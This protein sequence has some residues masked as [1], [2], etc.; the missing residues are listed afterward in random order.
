MVPF[1]SPGGPQ[2]GAVSTPSPGLCLVGLEST[3]QF[4][5]P[6]PLFDSAHRNTVEDVLAFL[7]QTHS[8]SSQTPGYPNSMTVRA[9][10]ASGA[11]GRLNSGPSRKKVCTHICSHIHTNTHMQT[12][13]YVHRKPCI[14]V[15]LHTG[16]SFSF[17]LLLLHSHGRS[18]VR[19]VGNGVNRNRPSL[20]AVH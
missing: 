16:C 1:T 19:Y 3:A 12:H 7:S 4:L 14:W 5:E 8:P 11:R 6:G 9:R 17:S 10:G 18:Q 2:G 13:T 20:Q 15:H